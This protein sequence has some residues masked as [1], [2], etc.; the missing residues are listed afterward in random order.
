MPIHPHGSH[1]CVCV[2][3]GYTEIV[4]AY[5]TLTCP[6]CSSRLRA[7]ETGEYRGGIAEMPEPINKVFMAILTGMG[8]AIGFYIVRKKLKLQS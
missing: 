3:C 1:E 6:G 5:N 7:S 4:D 8:I 2:N